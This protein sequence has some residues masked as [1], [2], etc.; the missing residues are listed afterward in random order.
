MQFDGCQGLPKGQLRQSTGYLGSMTN[1]VEAIAA[2]AGDRLR[3]MEESAMRAVLRKIGI[4]A[5]TAML[6]A[7]ATATFPGAADARGGH[8]GGGHWGHGHW[9]GGHG[10][11]GWGW[12][13]L[14]LGLAY[15]GYYAP[16]AYDYGYDTAY[17]YAQECY[18]R[19]HWVT[20]RYGERV[21]RR[22]YVC[23]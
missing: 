22:G 4:A 10:G 16:Y 14:G 20:N 11:W 17:A 8:W 1:K 9:G 19:R 6:I 5:A 12:G 18:V 2:E 13:G 3:S 23:Y 21:L 15:S 7:G